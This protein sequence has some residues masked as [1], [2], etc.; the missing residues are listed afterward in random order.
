MKN[1]VVVF[2]KNT[3]QIVVNPPDLVKYHKMP[4]AMVNPDLSLVK[5]EPP[6][7][8]KMSAGSVVPMSRPEKLERLKDID[9]EGIN[10]ELVKKIP[11]YKNYIF[12]IS[13]SALELLTALALG[14]H[15]G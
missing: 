15:N 13:V 11:F 14:L 1:T 4:N 9:S 5:G 6:H 12:W 10:V 3:A 8:W 7:F 2:K